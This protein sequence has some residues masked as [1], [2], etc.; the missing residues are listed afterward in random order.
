M[1][2]VILALKHSCCKAVNCY[3][4]ASTVYYILPAVI[5]F[6]Y[7]TVVTHETWSSFINPVND[8]VVTLAS[9]K[10]RKQ[11]VVT[12][13]HFTVYI[14]DRSHEANTRTYIH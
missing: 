9:R 8:I 10:M 4:I 14:T 13:C 3:A 5:H 2:V 6:S 7:S 12:T 1:F 11:F